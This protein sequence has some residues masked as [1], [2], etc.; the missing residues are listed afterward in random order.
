[1]LLTSLSFVVGNSLQ[2]HDP[3]ILLLVP[4]PSIPEWV[5]LN[6]SP[7]TQA[8]SNFQPTEDRLGTRPHMDPRPS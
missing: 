7:H 3:V 8:P 6:S 1:M 2:L 5:V 4:Q